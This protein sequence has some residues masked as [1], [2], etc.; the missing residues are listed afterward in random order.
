[1]S[2]S[3]HVGA[4]TPQIL[5]HRVVPLPGCLLSCQ[6]WGSPPSLSQPTP[7]N[8]LRTLN[9]WS[10]FLDLGL[11][12]V[13][14]YTLHVAILPVP[15]AFS[16]VCPIALPHTSSIAPLTAPFPHS[17]PPGPEGL[18]AHWGLCISSSREISGPV[19]ILFWAGVCILGPGQEPQDLKGIA[20]SGQ[21]PGSGPGPF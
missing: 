15:S 8:L 2:T 14:V 4:V 6:G 13:W 16:S 19:L 5:G 1:M 11:Q 10:S 3:D 18:A 7:N 20:K 17:Q 12:S 9:I 21:E